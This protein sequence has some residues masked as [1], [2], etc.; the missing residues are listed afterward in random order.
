MRA[1]GNHNN[2]I[3]I[4]EG[5]AVRYVK[6]PVEDY[7]AQ[8]LPGVLK[9][10]LGGDYDV[11]Y[12]KAQRNIRISNPNVTFSILGL[13]GGTTASSILGKGRENESTPANSFQGNGISNFSGTSSLLLVCN[14][15]LTQDVIFVN[16]QSVR[17]VAL[18]D[19]NSPNGA[20]CHWRNPGGWLDMGANLSYA[21]FRFLDPGTLQEIDFRGMGF[22]LQLGV[23][24]DDDDA[25]M[26]T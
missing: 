24:S 23:M 11:V 13:A 7:N 10:A 19:L 20:Y 12:D 21:T 26:F 1:T 22:T 17:C 14:K 18:I 9:T 16:N 6:I 5:S 2:Q 15:L 4:R 25:V 8:S 3:A